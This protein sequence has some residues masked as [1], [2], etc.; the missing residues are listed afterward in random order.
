MLTF[1]PFLTSVNDTTTASSET[2]RGQ[3]EESQALLLQ[4]Y[5]GDSLQLETICRTGEQRFQELG[6]VAGHTGNEKAPTLTVTH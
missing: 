3:T 2:I 6:F 5:P 4:T 1:K